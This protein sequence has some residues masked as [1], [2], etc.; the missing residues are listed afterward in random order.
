MAKVK[1]RECDICGHKLHENSVAGGYL[2]GYRILNRFF[3]KLDI[4]SNCMKKI[5]LLSI[6]V[7]EEKKCIDKF[8]DDG[9]EYSEIDDNYKTAYLHGAKNILDVLSHNRLKDIKLPL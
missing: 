3:N 2:D 8:F 6:D 9:N 5:K 1:Y 7:K 4:C